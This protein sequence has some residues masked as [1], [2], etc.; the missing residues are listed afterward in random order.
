MPAALALLFVV[1]AVEAAA[2]FQTLADGAAEVQLAASAFALALGGELAGD[3]PGDGLD[4]GDGLG[5]LCILEP[6]AYR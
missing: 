5:D 1:Q 4:D 2:G 3:L 6:G